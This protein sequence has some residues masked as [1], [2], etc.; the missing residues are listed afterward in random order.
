MPAW[1]PRWSRAIRLL[2]GAPFASVGRGSRR[3]TYCAAGTAMV[4]IGIP[5]AKAERRMKATGGP[6]IVAL[7]LA[8]PEKVDGIL[9]KWGDD[10]TKAA[11]G[12]LALDQLWLMTYAV[13]IAGAWT[14]VSE[15]LHVRNRRWLGRAAGAAGWAAV[16]AG[17]CDAVENTALLGVVTGRGPRHKL[18]AV[19]QGAARTKFTLLTVPVLGVVANV[20]GRRIAAR[21][22]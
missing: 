22:S 20:V 16:A 12:Q 7:E 9:A 19:A 13:L 3:L 21:R 18:A 10:G 1:S 8:G 5:M 2:S 17:A 4:G 14:A 15:R 11:R 6:G